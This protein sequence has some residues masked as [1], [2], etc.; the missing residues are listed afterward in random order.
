MPEVDIETSPLDSSEKSS[1]L[2]DFLRGGRRDCF[3][4]LESNPRGWVTAISPEI[5]Q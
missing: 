1:G 3:F 5:Y 4:L 2:N